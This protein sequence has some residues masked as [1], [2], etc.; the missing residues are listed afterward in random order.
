MEAPFDGGATVA[1]LALP[2]GWSPVTSRSDGRTLFVG[3]DLG[4]PIV[5]LPLEGGPAEAMSSGIATGAIVSAPTDIY[6]IA[7]S[8]GSPEGVMTFPRDGVNAWLTVSGSLQFFT[9][10]QRPSRSA[11]AS[12]HDHQ[13]R[14]RRRHMAVGRTPGPPADDRAARFDPGSRCHDR[15]A[16]GLS[17]GR[18]IFPR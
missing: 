10:L 3:N 1:I 16:R 6:W 12:L 5:A 18:P 4:G 2:D 7:A 13:H 14:W 11:R 17:P 15:R 8:S 9:Q